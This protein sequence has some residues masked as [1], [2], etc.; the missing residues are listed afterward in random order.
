[1]KVDALILGANGQLGSDLVKI[2]SQSGIEY[3]GLTRREFDVMSDDINTKLALYKPKYIINC[4]AITNVDGCE[5]MSKQAF[6]L[7]ANFVYLLAKY[8]EQNNI[9]LIHIS[10]DYVFS[11][12]QVT[13]YTEL[14]MPDPT[15]IYGISKY[16]AELL[17]KNYMTRYFIFRV[18]G[19]F[20]KAGAS[21]KGGNFI[22]TMQRLGRERDSVSVIANQFTSPTSTLAIARA[23]ALFIQKEICLFGIYHCASQN[24]CSWYEFAMQ[25]FKLSAIDCGK[26]I[27][28]EFEEYPF[29]A[30]RP[31]HSILNVDKIK[32]FVTMPTWQDSLDEYFTLL[33]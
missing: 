1:M 32:Q 8:C 22:T 12:T 7:N 17:I 9:I 18:S 6:K 24:G 13:P 33:S 28:A 15:S 30:K 2:F 10:T 5:N 19:L 25:I 29:K 4:I 3:I 20:G 26:L 11:G 31:K 14:D 27:P 21:G 16:T 23:I